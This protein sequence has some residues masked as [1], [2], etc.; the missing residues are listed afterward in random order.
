MIIYL[1]KII[2]NA[3][4]IIG[5]RN[6]VSI[7]AIL[8]RKGASEIPSYKSELNKYAYEI[9]RFYNSFLIGSYDPSILRFIID[10]NALLKHYKISA[11]NEPIIKVKE[12]PIS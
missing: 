2:K 8:I 6:K 1:L 10:Y 11:L 4:W 9:N 12:K 7:F 5:Y 3:L